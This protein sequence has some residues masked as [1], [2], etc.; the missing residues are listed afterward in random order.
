MS[1]RLEA[2]W[3]QGVLFSLLYWQCADT[4]KDKVIGDFKRG[5]S[6]N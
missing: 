2:A 6:K 1:L 5:N 3:F 4:I